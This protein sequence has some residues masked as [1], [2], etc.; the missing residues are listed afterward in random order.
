MGKGRGERPSSVRLAWGCLQKTLLS[1]GALGSPEGMGGQRAWPRART[2]LASL[3]FRPQSF[4]RLPLLLP[5]LGRPLRGRGPSGGAGLP[6]GGR[7]VGTWHLW[8]AQQG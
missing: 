7:E 5:E 8:E 1:G 2:G 4:P 6:G 3:P